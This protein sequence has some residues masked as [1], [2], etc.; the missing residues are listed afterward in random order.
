MGKNQDP[1]SGIRDK[2][3][4]SATL[5]RSLS[6]LQGMCHRIC[7]HSALFHESSFSSRFCLNLWVWQY[8]CVAM[9]YLTIFSPLASTVVKLVQRHA[10]FK[11]FKSPVFSWPFLSFFV[12]WNKNT[13]FKL[14]ADNVF[15]IRQRVYFDLCVM[16][17]LVNCKLEHPSIPQTR[18]AI[19]TKSNK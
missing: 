18:G 5:T 17:R 13:C 19:F 16:S 3:P 11:S 9:P 4:G 12:K 10:G 14:A 8:F 2:H 15:T 6:L 7:D 1:G